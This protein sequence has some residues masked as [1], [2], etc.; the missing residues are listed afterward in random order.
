MDPGQLLQGRTRET[1]IRRDARGRW[2]NGEDRIDHPNL[3]RSFDAWIDLADDGRFCLRNDINW[4]YVEIEGPPV[5]VRAV[6]IDGDAVHLELSDGRRERLDPATLREGED[7]GLYC[8]VR[9]GRLAARFDRG[10]AS[11]LEDR[12]GEDERGVYMLVDGERVRPP[13]VGDPLRWP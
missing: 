9:G 2:W 3:V 6:E 1:R 4:A 7:G 5:F 10:A 11:A 12:L 8:A 13:T